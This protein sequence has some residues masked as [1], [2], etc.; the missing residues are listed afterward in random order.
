MPS[1]SP[2]S[3]VFIDPV[4][5]L[6]RRGELRTAGDGRV[7]LSGQPLALWHWF[8]AQFVR[9]ARETGAMEIQFPALIERK[10]LE[11]AGY[12]DAFD[13]TAT[14]VTA[15]GAE[16]SHALTPAVCYHCYA[17]FAGKRL[18]QPLL[19]TCVGKCFRREPDGFESLARLWEFTMREVVFVGPAG[20]VAERRSEWQG[21]VSTFTKSLGLV[22]EIALATDPFFGGEGRGKKLLQ[23]LKQLKYEL[24]LELDGEKN[25]AVASFNL[26]ET[27]FGRRFGI[28]LADGT[29]AHS[30]CVAFGL[31]RWV[32]A[33]LTQRGV[34][35]AAEVCVKD[36][37]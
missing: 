22:G 1:Q 12:F 23:Q 28:T 10:T 34:E 18:E 2:T 29:T 33:F 26:H 13:E 37:L 17:Q 6:L 25:L 14:R 3:K 20:W 4:P 5:E 36:T 8:D 27:F 11:R 31:E 7:I 24:R 19:L 21:R 15:N 16:Q 9:L 30:G 32:L 35:A